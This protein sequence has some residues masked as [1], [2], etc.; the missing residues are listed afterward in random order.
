[1]VA[2]ATLIPY[3]GWGYLIFVL[4]NTGT[5][6]ASYGQPWY[7]IFGNVFAWIELAV[8]SYMILKSIKIVQL[9]KQRKTCFIDLD[10]KCVVRKTNGVWYQIFQTSMYALIVS[11]L[12]LMTSA[13]IEYFIISRI[14]FI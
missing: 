9:F 11:C 14:V 10:G 6:V 7:S 2:G 12:V 3:V 4:W 1:M 13:V 5:V 8:Y